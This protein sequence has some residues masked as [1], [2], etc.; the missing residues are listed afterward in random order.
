MS[1]AFESTSLAGINLNNR[2]FRSATHEHVADKNGFP[3]QE[4]TKKYVALA[5]GGIGCIIT[6]YYGISQQGKVVNVVMVDTDACVKPLSEMVQEV[7][8][9][10]T[11]I[12]TQI[13]HC[14]H[15]AA[16]NVTG[17]Q[18]LA[19]SKIGKAKAKKQ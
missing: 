4:I 12:I 14:G 16:T 11:P 1:R 18:I 5:K 17:F 3:T 2:F 13:V 9:H 19:P 8:S 15:Q 7:H 6:G 10:N